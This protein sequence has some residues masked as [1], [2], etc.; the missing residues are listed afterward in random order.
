MFHLPFSNIVLRTS[1]S[2]CLRGRDV[3]GSHDPAGNPLLALLRFIAARQ[4]QEF[5]AQQGAPTMNTLFLK[6]PVL[7][8]LATLGFAT[9]A[10]LTSAE[11]LQNDGCR[12]GPAHGG[13]E[14]L[15]PSNNR[16]SFA[17]RRVGI[18]GLIAL[19]GVG[20]L[21]IGISMLQTLPVSSRAQSRA[22]ISWR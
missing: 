22:L 21:C 15:S 6:I 13:G 4:R 18:T 11:R 14:Q 10:W 16:T 19:C 17:L 12:P 7:V 3:R 2:R 1:A 8:I 5:R 9:D 20:A